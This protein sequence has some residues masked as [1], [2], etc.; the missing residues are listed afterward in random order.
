MWERH[1]DMQIVDHTS[2]QKGRIK[3]VAFRPILSTSNARPVLCEITLATNMS[4]V[5]PNGYSPPAYSNTHDNQAGPAVTFVVA[6]LVLIALITL[7]TL[8]W[9]HLPSYVASLS[10]AAASEPISNI[11]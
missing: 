1:G 3:K 10:V 4:L 9:V 8:C 5:V 6:G 2:H 11:T 7:V